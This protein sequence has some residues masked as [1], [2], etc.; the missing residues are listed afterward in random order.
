MFHEELQRWIEA[1]Q[2]TDPFLAELF[3]RRKALAGGRA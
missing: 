3:D 1:W 2:P